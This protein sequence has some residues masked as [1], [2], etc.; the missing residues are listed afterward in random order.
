MRTIR[1]LRHDVFNLVSLSFL[2]A[3]DLIYLCLILDYWE[4]TNDR[5]AHEHEKMIHLLDVSNHVLYELLFWS[6]EFYLLADCAL[7]WLI[8]DCVPSN[9]TSIIIHHAVT[10]LIVAIPYSLR[11]FYFYFPLLMLVE[12]NTLC[13]IAKRNV[14]SG[15][16]LHLFL[17]FSFYITWV[18]FRLIGFPLA[19]IFL[20]QDYLSYTTTSSNGEYLNVMLFA[21]VALGALTAMSYLWTLELLLKS[22]SSSSSPSKQKITKEGKE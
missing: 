7:V 17:N 12:I 10:L 4:Q 14:P 3:V 9:P 5:H 13:L 18:A 6:T 16:G 20:W 11:Q 1:I 2:L 19:T 8:P 15:S 22:K 21:P